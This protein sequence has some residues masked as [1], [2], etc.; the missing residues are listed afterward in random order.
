M[1]ENR[2]LETLL[3]EEDLCDTDGLD[4]PMQMLCVLHTIERFNAKSNVMD[5][6]CSMH[7]KIINVYE[8]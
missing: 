7:G 8:V 4:G 3:H 5:G 6:A 1:F 2:R